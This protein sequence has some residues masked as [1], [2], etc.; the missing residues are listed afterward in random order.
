MERLTVLYDATCTLCVRCKEFLVHQPSFL[1]I[2]LLSC[3]S[4]A[5]RERYGSVPWLAEELVVVSDEGDVWAGP[6]AFLVCL[7][8]LTEWREWSYRLS[9]PAL[10]PLAE[11]FFVAVSSRRRRIGAFLG[12][13]NC[14]DG[15]CALPQHS[16]R[17][18]YR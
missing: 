3:Q 11:R 15:A 9:G 14:D 8:A 6:A 13:V 10:A 12:P 16:T 17:P 4:A 2:D 1:P 18:V 5:A 7:W